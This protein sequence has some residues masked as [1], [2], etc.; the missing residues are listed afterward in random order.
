MKTS[1]YA[2]DWIPSFAPIP[3][4]HC[5]FGASRGHTRGGAGHGGWRWAW[6]STAILEVLIK[7]ENIYFPLHC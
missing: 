3:L 7:S 2:L 1:I 5:F 6:A 4:R